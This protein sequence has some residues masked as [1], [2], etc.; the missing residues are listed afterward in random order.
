M[1]LLRKPVRR[2]DIPARVGF[3]R[4][5]GSARVTL[6]GEVIGTG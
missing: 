1:R 5:S 3:S 6:V 2:F 4:L